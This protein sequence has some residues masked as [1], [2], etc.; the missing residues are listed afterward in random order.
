MTACFM[1]GSPTAWDRP[2]PALPPNAPAGQV[3]GN[4][5]VASMINLGVVELLGHPNQLEVGGVKKKSRVP[6]G[7]RAGVSLVPWSHVSWSRTT[8]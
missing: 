3:A 5:T 8:P 7:Y 6:G 1:R 2:V 4:A